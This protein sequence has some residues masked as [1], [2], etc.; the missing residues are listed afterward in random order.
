MSSKYQIT[1]PRLV[2]TH[3]HDEFGGMCYSASNPEMCDCYLVPKEIFEKML[4][5]PSDEEIEAEVVKGHMK[6]IGPFIESRKSK[7]K[8]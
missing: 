8:L 3:A 6:A 1:E 5:P 2:R 7:V 4:N